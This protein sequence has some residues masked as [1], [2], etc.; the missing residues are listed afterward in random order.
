M[1]MPIAMNLLRDGYELA[2]YGRNPNP[3]QI[4]AEAGAKVSQS[5]FEAAS[6]VDFFLTCLSDDHAVEEVLFGKTGA[7]AGLRP[8][9]VFID[10]GTS[11]ADLAR[12][13]AESLREKGVEALDAPTSGGDIAAQNGTLTIMVGGSESAFH[14][15]TALF[16]VLGRRITY[17]G[18]SGAGQV[19][20]ACNQ[21][22]VAATM[23][24]VAEALV[25]ASKSGI[26]LELL[27]EAMSAG[28]ANCWTLTTRIPR[29][30]SGDRS[31]GMRSR[32]FLKD[33]GI[34]LQTA[35]SNNISMPMTS[36]AREFYAAMIAR[37]LGEC[38]NSAIIDV[39]ANF[40]GYAD[41][42]KETQN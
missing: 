13:V 39:I 27:V 19:A 28:A 11:S 16:N 33:L 41:W 37:G 21:T 38:D 24:G 32:L 12:K 30:L 26:K 4:I 1:G 17:M 3:L 20:K 2:V 18:P 36:L 31:P 42:D 23:V 25:L 7:A 10:L 9:S 15:C 22:I 5:P 35:R 34:I 8:G 6:Q 14:R 29:L 40:S